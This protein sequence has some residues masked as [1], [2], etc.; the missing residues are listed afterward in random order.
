[1]SELEGMGKELPFLPSGFHKNTRKGMEL[2][3]LLVVA[4]PGFCLQGRILT[5]RS[6][7]IA[8]RGGLQNPAAG[9]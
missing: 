9:V 4:T 8:K 3:L 1:M 2:G 5:S 6:K 7:A